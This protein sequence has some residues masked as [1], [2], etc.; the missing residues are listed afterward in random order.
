VKKTLQCYA[1]PETVAKLNAIASDMR[2]NISATIREI[3][4]N[5]HARRF[6]PQPQIR[7]LLG[8]DE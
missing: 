4:E 7:N 5:E 6:P 3:I 8:D 2:R 1:G